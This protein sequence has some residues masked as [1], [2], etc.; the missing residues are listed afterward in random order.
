MS[1]YLIMDIEITDE[2]SYAEYRKLVPP[3]IEKFGGTYHARGGWAKN[4]EGDW[5]PNRIVV[6]E[7]ESQQIAEK[8]LDSPEYAPVK[9]IRHGASISKGILVEATH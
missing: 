7:F 2:E 4:V 5:D 9:R 1:V 6:L 8:F 3:L